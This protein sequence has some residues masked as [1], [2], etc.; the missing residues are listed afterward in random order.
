MLQEAA[1][2]DIERTFGVLQHRWGVLAMPCRLWDLT[3]VK[4]LMTACIILHNMIVEER[5]PLD[6]YLNNI[7]T[8]V[9][10]TIQ[11]N[12]RDPEIF[13]NINS[14]HQNHILLRQEV[15]HHRL[16]SD[17]KVHNWMRRGV[18]M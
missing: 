14:I 7:N 6:P 4:R 8:E 17:L 2:K 16:T 11:D 18:I 10:P 9:T 5:H 12:H 1:R 13:H 3:E 15:I